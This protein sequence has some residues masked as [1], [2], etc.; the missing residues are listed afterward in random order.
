MTQEGYGIDSSLPGLFVTPRLTP[1]ELTFVNLTRNSNTVGE[2]AEYTFTLRLTHLPIP[3]I[4]GD[5]KVFI[6]LA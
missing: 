5:G 1:G 6:Q 4:P 2:L 3:A